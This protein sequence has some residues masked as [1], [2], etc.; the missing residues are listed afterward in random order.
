MKMSKKISLLRLI[1]IARKLLLWVCFQGQ[2]WKKKLLIII[3]KVLSLGLWKSSSS[4]LW[5][6]L[7]I[8]LAKDK[9]LKLIWKFRRLMMT[10]RKSSNL[11]LY[12]I[13][14]SN[15]QRRKDK[16]KKLPHLQKKRPVTTTDSLMSS[17]VPTKLKSKPIESNKW[18]KFKILKC[19]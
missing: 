13:K 15:L 19:I 11:K 8:Y 16:S 17:Q 9:V 5:L 18:L 10:L 6:L 2:W 3:M 1:K 4:C 7:R 12:L 14:K